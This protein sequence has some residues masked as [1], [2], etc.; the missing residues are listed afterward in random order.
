LP[1]VDLLA[2]KLSPA[3][4]PFGTRSQEAFRNYASAVAARERAAAVEHLEG[5]AKA[6][7]HFPLAYLDWA[8]GLVAAARGGV[9]ATVVG[10]GREGEVGEKVSGGGPAVGREGTDRG[11]L[12]AL[13]ASMLPSGESREEPLRILARLP[14]ADAKVQ[15]QLA[16]LEFSRRAFSAAARDYRA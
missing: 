7:P 16:E 9:E 15:K 12:E 11:R 5:A 4:R 14:P 6:D 1:L 8:G 10:A 2:R 3:A 13:R